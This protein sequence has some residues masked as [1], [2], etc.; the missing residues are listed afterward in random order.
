MRCGSVGVAA[1]ERGE[2]DETEKEAKVVEGREKESCIDNESGGG[3]VC[4]CG[5]REE[6]GEAGSV[7][8][9]VWRGVVA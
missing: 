5:G 7:C 3:Y 4:V 2:E 1:A 9:E 8:V 6:C